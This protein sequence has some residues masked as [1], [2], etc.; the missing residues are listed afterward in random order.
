MQTK[1]I[2]LICNPWYKK[3]GENTKKVTIMNNPSGPFLGDMNFIYNL[4]V[5]LMSGQIVSILFRAYHRY[6]AD[7]LIP[8]KRIEENKIQLVDFNYLKRSCPKTLS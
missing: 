5:F 8:G 6:L 3:E 4:C 2:L 7:S 1:N